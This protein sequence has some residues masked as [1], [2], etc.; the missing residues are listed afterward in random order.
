MIAIWVQ[1]PRLKIFGFARRPDSGLRIG[2]IKSQLDEYDY[3]YQWLVRREQ[4][5]QAAEV[6]V[7]LV[8]LIGIAALAY[9]G[10]VA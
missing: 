7:F 2:A 3:I 6:L 5:L 9:V 4:T 8:T 10:F 1:S